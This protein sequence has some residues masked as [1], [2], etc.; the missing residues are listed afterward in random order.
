MGW[1]KG[2][3]AASLHFFIFWWCLITCP[4]SPI[5]L[6]AIFGFS[7]CLHP[8][9]LPFSWQEGF[10]YQRTPSGVCCST[11]HS[12]AYGPR[13]QKSS[14][15]LWGHSEVPKTSHLCRPPWAT[16]GSFSLHSPS[17][18]WH[19]RELLQTPLK[20]QPP[21]NSVAE[22]CTNTEPSAQGRGWGGRT[23][24]RVPEHGLL[25]PGFYFFSPK[26]G[27][28]RLQTHQAKGCAQPEPCL[29]PQN[30][31]HRQGSARQ[32]SPQPQTDGGKGKNPI[33][34]IT[35][36]LLPPQAHPKN[37]SLRLLAV[38]VGSMA[39][40]SSGGDTLAA[41]STPLRGWGPSHHPGPSF[42]SE[43]K[44]WEAA[45]RASDPG[46]IFL[47]L[48]LGRPQGSPGSRAVHAGGE[49]GKRAPLTSFVL[50]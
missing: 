11:R 37:P 9:Q 21:H 3:Q 25:H 2:L 14:G 28:W 31:T 32:E 17:C 38:S 6:W 49:Q 12:K 34:T 24:L 41:A 48:R 22:K 7:R 19:R 4:S 10:L 39:G 43:P 44:G 40:S 30:K 5:A 20:R 47:S 15:Q 50:P 45:Q 13:G 36:P 26:L 42:L 23:H 46:M 8:T 16:T 1:C 29:V 18:V 27:T 35:Q 33:T